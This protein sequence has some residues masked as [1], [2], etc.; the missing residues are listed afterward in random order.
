M[1]VGDWLESHSARWKLD[2][3]PLFRR[4]NDEEDQEVC[5]LSAAAATLYRCGCCCCCCSLPLL[6]LSAAAAALCPCCSCSLMLLLLL[7]LLSTAAAPLCCCCCCCSLP[8]TGVDMHAGSDGSCHLP[9]HHDGFAHNMA[10]QIAGDKTWHL[11]APSASGSLLFA[12]DHSGEDWVTTTGHCSETEVA[13]RQFAEL[14]VRPLSIRVKQGECLMLPPM[15]WHT[16]RY[17]QPSAAQAQQH[18]VAR[19]GLSVGVSIVFAFAT[20]F[21][22]T[23]LELLRV[24]PMSTL[25]QLRQAMPPG[26][27]MCVSSDPGAS[28]ESGLALDPCNVLTMDKMVAK[29]EEALHAHHEAE[30]KKEAELAAAAG[31][32]AAEAAALADAA[33]ALADKLEAAGLT[34]EA[35]KLHVII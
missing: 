4:Q 12:H 17:H 5:F 23:A 31:E 26:Q 8:V 34:E 3:L 27:A 10:C 30:D 22:P 29:L 15:W 14:D 35:T 2:Q 7:L 32:A 13:P 19:M 9:L 24:D 1:T 18:T 16:T 28:S 25:E 33:G 6:L 11:F 20:R 21:S